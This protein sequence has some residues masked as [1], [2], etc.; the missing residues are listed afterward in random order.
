MEH[1]ALPAAVLILS[2]TVERYGI[3]SERLFPDADVGRSAARSESM[4]LTRA[5]MIDAIVR[6]C[7]LTGEPGLGF[8]AGLQ[9][10]MYIHDFVFSTGALFAQT[11]RDTLTLFLQ[12]ARLH[13]H[14]HVPVLWEQGDEA[15]LIFDEQGDTEAARE[16]VLICLLTGFAQAA[17]DVA[18][19]DPIERIDLAIAEPPYLR[20][21]AHL[22][23]TGKMHF[24][25]PQSRLHG[26][27]HVLNLRLSDILP[28]DVVRI[29]AQCQRELSGLGAANLRH[30]IQS[31]LQSSG[32]TL[33]TL[34]QA[35]AHLSM[36]PRTLKRRLAEHGTS[37]SLLCRQQ[38]MSRA[39]QLLLCGDDSIEQI[40]EQLGFSDAPSL[41]R[42]FRRWTG[43]TPARYR[44]QHRLRR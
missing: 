4:R 8:A 10:R 6:A 12:M 7:D 21:F 33:P 31:L 2:Q 36:S 26:Q 11:I 41:I 15:A 19:V 34:G 18:G 24:G 32:A 39:E 1:L 5:Q 37:Y 25:Q 22:A 29:K 27:S 42:A 44:A 16:V 14:T 13:G 3:A 20:Q 43:L 28:R 17:A 35:A 40:A 38:L 30:R 9:L 23:V